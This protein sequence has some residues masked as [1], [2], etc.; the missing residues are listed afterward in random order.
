M[1]R[2]PPRRGPRCCDKRTR[3]LKARHRL[4]EVVVHHGLVDLG[5]ADRIRVAEMPSP[6]HWNELDGLDERE[7]R[8]VLERRHVGWRESVAKG[9]TSMPIEIEEF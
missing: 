2:K 1:R 7:W 8:R 6:G 9:R 3:A 4:L 5:E